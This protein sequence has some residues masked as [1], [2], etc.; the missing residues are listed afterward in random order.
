MSQ[1]GDRLKVSE[2]KLSLAEIYSG[3]EGLRYGLIDD[4]GTVTAATQRAASLAGI[5]NY[6]VVKPFISKPLS[7]IFGFSSLEELKSQTGLMPI[8]YYLYFESE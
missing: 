1:R 3:V 5:R 7:A 2:E 6:E 8:Y 4:I